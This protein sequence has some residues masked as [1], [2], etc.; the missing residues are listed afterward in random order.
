LV[1]KGN[2]PLLK[3]TRFWIVKDRIVPEDE[4]RPNTSHRIPPGGGD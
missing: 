1:L 4:T 3:S 2:A